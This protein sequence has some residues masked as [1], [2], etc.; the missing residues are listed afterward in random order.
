MPISETLRAELGQYLI[1]P[2]LRALRLRRSMGLTQLGQRTGLS[3]ALLSKIENAKLVPTIPTLLRMARVF[4][5]TLDYFF[6]NEHRR[7]IIAVTRQQE[8]EKAGEERLGTGE[9][10]QLLRLDLG[11]GERKFHAYLAEFPATVEAGRGHM[12]QGFEFV[13]V[14]VGRLELVIGSDVTVL[15]TGD[16]IYFD[17]NL[18][19]GYRSLDQRACTAFMVLAYPERN[20]TERRMDNLTALHGSRKPPVTPSVSTSVAVAISEPATNGSDAPSGTGV[21]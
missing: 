5:V 17:S 21:D 20:L 18:R 7:R 12:H 13:H 14:L 6:Q 8:R 9:G 15:E 11:A 2:K 1:G 4:D 16:S 10:F 19:H 3:P